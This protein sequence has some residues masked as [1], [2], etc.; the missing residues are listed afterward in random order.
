[1]NAI[2]IESVLRSRTLEMFSNE[3]YDVTS[4][5]IIELFSITANI[6]I[7]ISSL[8]I[9]KNIDSITESK[10]VITILK[11]LYGTIPFAIQFAKL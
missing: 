7:V 11:S 9:L 6:L 4:K 5:N 3:W 1:M 10:G 2:K 8:H